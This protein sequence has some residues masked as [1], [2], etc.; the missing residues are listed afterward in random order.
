L[1]QRR[2]GDAQAAAD[3]A[4]AHLAEAIQA[5]YHAGEPVFLYGH[6]DGRLGRYP[7]VLRR[8]LEATAGYSGL[9]RTDRTTIARW[10]R[11]RAAIEFSVTRDA[12]SFVVR[13]GEQSNEWTPAIEFWRGEHVAC[14]PLSAPVTRFSPE[15]VAYERRRPVALPHAVRIDAAHSLKS[16]VRRYLDW[17][18]VTPVDEINSGTLRGWLKKTLRRVRK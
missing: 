14:M 18:K 16:S 6:P 12:E 5:K 15:A 11:Q 3:V 17:E 13:G 8:T 7:H 4:A 1:N 9:W 10:W 2:G